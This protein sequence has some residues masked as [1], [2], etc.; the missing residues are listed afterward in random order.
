VSPHETDRQA[1]TSLDYRLRTIL[2]EEYQDTYQSM[3]PKPMKSAGLVFDADGQVAWDEIWGSFCD[4]AMAGGPPHKGALLEP[5]TPA[6][7]AAR[8]DRHA[9]VVAEIRRGITLA[10]DLRTVDAPSPGWVRVEALNDAMAGWLLRAITMEN[11]AVRADGGWIDLP[12]APHF[13]L[14]KEIKNVVTVIAKTCHYWLGHMP[15]TQRRRIAHLFTLI[16]GE[17]PLI[18]PAYGTTADAAPIA[19]AIEAA[20]GLVRSRHRYAGW[21]GVECASVRAAIWMMRAL[22]VHNVLARREETVLF[23]PVDPAGDPGGRCVA[24]AVARLHRL[25]TAT[26]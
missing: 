8:P 1:L 13:R 5:G 12:A 16:A 24:D 2:P 17:Q 25:S 15:L 3:E 9:E 4:L 18:A 10:T 19:A 20:T 6:D 22:V 26:T 14:E 21:I 23:V 7:I 11:V